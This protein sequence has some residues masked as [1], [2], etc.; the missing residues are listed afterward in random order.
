MTSSTHEKL[1]SSIA[2]LSPPLSLSS[3]TLEL[4]SNSDLINLEIIPTPE[5]TLP[6][7]QPSSST[8]TQP[9]SSNLKTGHSHTPPPTNLQVTIDNVTY[10]VPSKKTYNILEDPVF[11]DSGIL[12]PVLQPVKNPSQT[13]T[14]SDDFFRTHSHVAIL[15]PCCHFPQQFLNFCFFK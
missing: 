12:P 1:F 5:P 13:N 9:S 6:T 7:I 10:S 3:G 14:M 8:D 2:F 15:L 4:P 11:I